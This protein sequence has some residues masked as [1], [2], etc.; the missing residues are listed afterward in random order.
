[1]KKFEE[2][3]DSEIEEVLGAKAD[4]FQKKEW[5]WFKKVYKTA[6][7]ISED[8][9]RFLLLKF[10]KFHYRENPFKKDITN[11]MEVDKFI[12]SLRK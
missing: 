10:L 8:E 3:P 7:S 2:V 1:M 4:S 12:N 9:M 5:D 11:L 6:M